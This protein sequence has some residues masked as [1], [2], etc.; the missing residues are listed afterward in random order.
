M[1]VK[2]QKGF[3]I[4]IFGL[5]SGFTCTQCGKQFNHGFKTKKINTSED[6]FLYLCSSCKNQTEEPEKNFIF[7]VC[8]GSCYPCTQCGEKLK[9]GYKKIQNIIPES[10][11]HK[12]QKPASVKTCHCCND[13]GKTFVHPSQLLCHSN[14]HSGKWPYRC[15][16]CQIDFAV[17]S[18]LERPFET[19]RYHT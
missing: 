12:G 6:V 3:S 14:E 4:L 5:G 13:C 8:P 19:T 2:K 11:I 7:I 16:F 10:H 1:Q 9:T 15:L 17:D 18:R